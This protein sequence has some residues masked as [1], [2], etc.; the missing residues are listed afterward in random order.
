M[1]DELLQWTDAAEPPDASPP[2]NAPLWKLL[3]VDDDPDVH[4][5]TH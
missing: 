2:V 4:G 5:V 1:I 3:V